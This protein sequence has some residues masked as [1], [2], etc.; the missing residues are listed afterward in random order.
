MTQT[1]ADSANF[2]STVKDAGMK[3]ARRFVGF[4][5]KA[6]AKDA[7]AFAQRIKVAIEAS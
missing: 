5:R 1:V 7:D 4:A 6:A 3:T 2:I